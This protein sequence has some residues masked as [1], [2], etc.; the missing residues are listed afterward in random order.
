[1][2]LPTTAVAQYDPPPL[3]SWNSAEIS[4]GALNLN[5]LVLDHHDLTSLLAGSQLF[6]PM[7]L[8]DLSYLSDSTKLG[9]GE[10][11]FGIS[12]GLLPFHRDG[13]PGPELR[14]GILHGSLSTRTGLYEHITR[15]P[16]DTLVSTT[17]GELY[18]AD[19]VV[20]ETYRVAHG[21]ERLG[22]TA[23]LIWQSQGRWRFYGGIGL[24]GG[25][26]MN[27]RT[28]VGHERTVRL[29][30][31]RHGWHMATLVPD[32]L[33]KETLSP[34]GNGGWW[35]GTYLP[36]G[37]DFQLSHKSYFWS[38]VRLFLELRPHLVIDETSPLGPFMAAGFASTSG[39]RFNLQIPHLEPPARPSVD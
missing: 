32:L 14:L 37:V 8:P 13:R 22:F 28:E 17:T 7:L 6:P 20:K 38:R 25:L 1:M 35:L 2:A 19:S 33:E 30:E 24:Q 29:E 3:S 18:P 4:W 15:T 31:R 27:A 34:E 39:L 11:L 10:M 21:A 16:Y 26:R 23:S 12:V 5:T 36:M 9:E